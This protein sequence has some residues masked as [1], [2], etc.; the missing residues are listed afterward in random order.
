MV[1]VFPLSTLGIVHFSV[2]ATYVVG[3]GLGGLIFG[4]GMALAGC[5][6]GTV[7]AA[8]PGGARDVIAGAFPVRS[9]TRWCTGR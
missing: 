3:M 7:L 5:C 9:P 2:K 8:I 4:A 1:I 6:P